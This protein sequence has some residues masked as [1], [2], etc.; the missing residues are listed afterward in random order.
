[1]NRKDRRMMKSYAAA[2]KGSR[3]LI[4]ENGTPIGNQHHKD[5][6]HSFFDPRAL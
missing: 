1:M 5:S 3:F 6:S 4:G 2:A